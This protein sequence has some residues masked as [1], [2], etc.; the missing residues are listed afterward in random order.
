MYV[1]GYKI[2]ALIVFFFFITSGFNLVPEDMMENRLFSKGMDYA[3][4]TITG[5]V[6]IDSFCIKN[7]LKPDKFL[8]LI[9]IFY[10]FL[11]LCVIYNKFAVGIG[12]TEIIRTARYNVLWITAYLVFRN[13]SGEQLFYLLKCLFWVTVACA[14]LYLLQIILNTHILNETGKSS[15]R[16]FGMKFPRFYNQPDMM[17]IF[18]FMAIYFNPHKGST[19]I[20]TTA[21]LVAALLGAFHRSLVIAFILAVS[22]GYVI[23]LPRVKRV[24]I[25]TSFAIVGSLVIVFLGYRFASSRTVQDIAL[26]TSGNLSIANV[27]DMDIDIEDLQTS[28]FTFRIAHLLERNQYLLEHPKAMLFGAGLMTEDS[29]ITGSMFDFNIGLDDELSGKTVQLDTGDISYSILLLRYGYLGTLLVLSLY[30]FLMV[31][32]YKNRENRVGLFSF[33][34]FIV[35]MVGTFFSQILVLPVSFL[36]PLITYSIVQKNRLEHK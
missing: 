21:I 27:G 17:Q 34:Y 18:T 5:M 36:V 6:I 10:A 13:L 1:W 33:V 26:V 20:A 2:P 9:L 30:L 35:V 23:R 28:T 22:V 8:W 16:I 4:L 7:Y 14:S 11:A 3:I 29:K 19:K 25:L 24:V 31:Y 32:F 12:W 15:A